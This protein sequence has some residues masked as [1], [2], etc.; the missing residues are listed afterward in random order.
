MFIF[1]IPLYSM[2][3]IT[4]QHI[5]Y[6]PSL[7]SWSNHA[8]FPALPIDS[9]DYCPNSKY[10]CPQNGWRRCKDLI[11]A[12]QLLWLSFI[13]CA[14]I[15]LIN[16]TPLLPQIEKA[17]VIQTMLFVSGFNT[18]FQS[19]FGTR[20]PTVVTASY[21]YVIP[22][23]SILLASRYKDYSDPHEVRLNLFSSFWL[24]NNFY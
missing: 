11:L 12:R 18:L 13:F 3:T 10:A 21:T 20:L 17:R 24:K 4:K 8:G 14:C 23:T 15:F 9:W 1:G 2:F 7:C 19:L 22:T 6:L 16:F 5:I